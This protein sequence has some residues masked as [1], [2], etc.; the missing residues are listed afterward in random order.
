ML[1]LEKD[2]VIHEITNS[3]FTFSKTFIKLKS[4]IYFQRLICYNNEMT[5]EPVVF[6]FNETVDHDDT[7]A[8]IYK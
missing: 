8:S 3:S 5:F 1:R 4:E 7:G 2:P 6:F